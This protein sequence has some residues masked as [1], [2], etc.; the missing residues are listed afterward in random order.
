MGAGETVVTLGILGTVA[1]G[2]FFY[3]DAIK[4][5]F[6]SESQKEADAKKTEA[7]AKIDTSIANS[8][9]RLSNLITGNQKTSKT[10]K[11]QAMINAFGSSDS[12]LDPNR[13]ITKFN[14]DGIIGFGFKNLNS[15]AGLKDTPENR[16]LLGLEIEKAKTQQLQLIENPKVSTKTSIQ[17]RSFK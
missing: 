13:E 8:I 1:A 10:T 7:S 16:K 2:I 15:G 4:N 17:K 11:E 14:P 3:K 6:A 12:V 9:D 5:A